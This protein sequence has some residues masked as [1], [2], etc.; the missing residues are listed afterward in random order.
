MMRFEWVSPSGANDGTVFGTE[1]LAEVSEDGARAGQIGITLDTGSNGIM[2]YGDRRT[3]ILWLAGM[4]ARLAA[5][6]GV[7][8][9]RDLEPGEPAGGWQ[10]LDD[11]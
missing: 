6:E 1:D 3:L 9:G 4:Q 10:G 5:G 2:I 7:E 8:V 11:D